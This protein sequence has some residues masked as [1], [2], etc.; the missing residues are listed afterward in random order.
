MMKINSLEVDKRSP[1]MSTLE[2][3]S[4]GPRTRFDADALA[5]RV[6]TGQGYYHVALEPCTTSTAVLRAIL[7]LREQPWCSQ[8]TLDEFSRALYQACV[9]VFD[10][11]PQALFQHADCRF[12]WHNGQLQFDESRQR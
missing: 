2:K 8:S 6:W 7:E 4:Q 11:T 3:T 5:I 9:C 1:H 10:Q 12:D